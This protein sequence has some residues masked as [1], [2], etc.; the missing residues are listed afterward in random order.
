MTYHNNNTEETVPFG[1]SSKVVEAST[2]SSRGGLLKKTF[3]VATTMLVG[4]A[5]TT[6]SG[7]GG[8]DNGLAVDLVS[9]SSY[10]GRVGNAYLNP[11][12]QGTAMFGDYQPPTKYGGGEFNSHT[13]SRRYGEGFWDFNIVPRYFPHTYSWETF[14]TVCAGGPAEFFFEEEYAWAVCKAY[15]P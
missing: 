5:L 8:T 14:C 11:T 12:C 4:A 9:D 1:N 13:P 15:K 2:S 10:E 7:K 3:V 6:H